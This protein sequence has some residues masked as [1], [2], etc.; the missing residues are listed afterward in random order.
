MA[1]LEQFDLAKY[2]DAVVTGLSAKHTKPIPTRSA[3]AQK[4]KVPPKLPDDRR[5]TVDIRA[6]KSAGAQ[7]A[8]C[9]AALARSLS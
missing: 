3:C 6:G 1:F 2:F 8:G 5:P 4:M 7:T 9:C